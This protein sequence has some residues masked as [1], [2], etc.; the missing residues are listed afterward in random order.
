MGGHEADSVKHLWEISLEEIARQI[1]LMDSRLFL[2]I[3]G[4]SL[5]HAIKRRRSA[6]MECEFNPIEQK[7]Q[8][9]T[10]FRS[11]L[12]K[13]TKMVIGSILESNTAEEFRAKIERF[14]Q[15]AQHL[16]RMDNLSSFFAVSNGIQSSY[17]KSLSVIMVSKV[18]L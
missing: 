9:I 5:V 6:V 2:E 12:A 17:V 4:L 16:L 18:T 13:L 15:L 3:S 7:T 14:H 10:I 11:H 8:S 1:A